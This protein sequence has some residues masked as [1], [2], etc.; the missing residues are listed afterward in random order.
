MILSEEEIHLIPVVTDDK[1][2]LLRNLWSRWIER[3]RRHN[4]AIEHRTESAWFRIPRHS[5]V[6]SILSERPTHFFPELNLNFEELLSRNLQKVPPLRFI[7][8]E[9]LKHHQCCFR[10][11]C[12]GI[13]LDPR[14]TF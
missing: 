2:L 3:V 13:D 5:L 14:T 6:A 4:L 8:S 7:K 10:R 9:L 1:W 11:S 12:S